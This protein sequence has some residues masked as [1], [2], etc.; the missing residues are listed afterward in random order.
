M[1]VKLLK[2]HRGDRKGSV[3]T[4]SPNEGFGLID[5][6]IAEVTKDMTDSDYKITSDEVQADATTRLPKVR[7]NI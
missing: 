2:D 3:K 7:K 6:G 1:R 4:V 5:A